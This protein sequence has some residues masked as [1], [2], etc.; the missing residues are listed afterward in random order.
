MVSSTWRF[1]SPH[2]CTLAASC[3]VGPPGSTAVP[4]S[5]CSR[6]VDT[7]MSRMW[8]GSVNRDPDHHATSARLHIKR[9]EALL[10][11]YG[12]SRLILGYEIYL[13]VRSE[14]PTHRGNGLSES[15]G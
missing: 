3:L 7:A 9:N 1:I 12:D 8:Y 10:C 6:V 5:T 2:C 4:V 11:M 13:V 14:R 15:A